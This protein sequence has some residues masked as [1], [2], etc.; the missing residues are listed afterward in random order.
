MNKR[1]GFTLIE[2]IVAISIIAILIGMLVVGIQYVGASSREKATRIT[3]AN[4]QSMLTELET[5]A[6][7]GRLPYHG[8]V[9]AP[10]GYIGEGSP[11][12]MNDTFRNTRNAMAILQSVPANAS[13]IAQL[14]PETMAVLQWQEGVNYLKDDQVV[15]NG[16]V[17]HATANTNA[18]PP[19][20]A[21]AESANAVPLPIDAW[22]NPI[23]FVAPPN[24]TQGTSPVWEERYGLTGVDIEGIA[25]NVRIV[26][27]GGS[28]YPVNS[29]YPA[30]SDPQA[31]QRLQHFRPFWVSAGP[32]G[33][34][35]THDDNI[36]SFEN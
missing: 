3:L 13:A 20:G 10:A 7:L 31:R 32:D 36:Y 5:T 24:L 16:V 28:D 18:Q 21:W 30:S 9:P 2:L 29:K 26:N 1:K 6:G 8:Y 23:I 12:R 25:T 34:F 11:N 35:Q 33:N 4:L 22:N 17:Y 27:P 15:H 14:P 19:G